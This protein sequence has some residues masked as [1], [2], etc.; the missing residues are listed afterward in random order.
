M[1]FEYTLIVKVNLSSVN[2]EI[3]K[4]VDEINDFIGK[5]DLMKKWL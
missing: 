5:W 2:S 4:I 1:T 3:K